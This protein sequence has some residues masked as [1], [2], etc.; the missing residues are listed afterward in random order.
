MTHARAVVGR[1]IK[2]VMENN[3]IL[4]V[5]VKVILENEQGEY[6]LLRRSLDK[7]PEVKG[8]WDIV[9]G[10]INPGQKLIENLRRE[11]REET[12]LKLI[13]VPRLIAAQDIIPNVERHVV[14]LTY[15]GKAEG[16][17]V[18]DT[19]ENDLY[20][21]YSFEELQALHDVDIYFKELLNIKSLWRK[22]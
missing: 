11:I 5:G 4:Q 12:G 8:R 22:E 13:D 18:L 9:G 3:V 7:Y 1:S 21:W 19:S 20:R 15:V 17:I 14:R 10:R 6:L 2:S 16:N